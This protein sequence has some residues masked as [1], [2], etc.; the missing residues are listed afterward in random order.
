MSIQ[1]ELGVLFVVL[2]IVGNEVTS[3]KRELNEIR[4]KLMELSG[5]TDEAH[6]IGRDLL[7][8]IETDVGEIHTMLEVQ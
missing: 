2:L 5:A 8:K 3:I 1:I 7:Q 6:R 4:D